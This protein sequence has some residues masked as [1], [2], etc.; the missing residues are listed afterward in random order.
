MAFINVGSQRLS[1]QRKIKQELS[2][3][4]VITKSKA[5]VCQLKLEKFVV[6]PS[7]NTNF[8]GWWKDLDDDDVV[9]VR[10]PHEQHGLRSKKSNR[11]K[12]GVKNDFLNC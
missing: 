6:L 10:Y 1:H 2:Q 4:P 9:E 8:Q 5:D 12:T 3:C 7:D 11:A